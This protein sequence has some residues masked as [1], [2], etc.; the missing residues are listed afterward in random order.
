MAIRGL[1]RGDAFTW[2]FTRDTSIP[3]STITTRL[4]E[5]K[6]RPVILGKYKIS[7]TKAGYTIEKISR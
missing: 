4:N 7:Y 1:S 5:A 6:T 3:D 2:L